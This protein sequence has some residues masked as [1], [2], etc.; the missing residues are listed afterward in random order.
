MSLTAEQVANTEHEL[1]A[2]KAEAARLTTRVAVLT[3]QVETLTADNIK[4]RSERDT[5]MTRAVQMQT[6]MES[7][8]A[9]LIDGITK[10]R[11]NRR[12]RQERELGVGQE[13]GSPFARGGTVGR[14]TSEGERFIPETQETASTATQADPPVDL[15][16]LAARIKRPT[17]GALPPETER[18]RITRLAQEPLPK[19]APSTRSMIDAIRSPNVAFPQ[20]G[21]RTD[22]EDSRLPT[23]EFGESADTQNLRELEQRLSRGT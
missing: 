2:A 4:L 9:G 19:A 11:V 20:K 5:E 7:V 17:T 6:I 3:Q 16:E 22:I 12:E 15:D 23:V 21:V 1:I 10:M 13:G 14:A 18:Q 8:S